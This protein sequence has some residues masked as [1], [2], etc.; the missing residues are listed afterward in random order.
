MGIFRLGPPRQSA[1]ACV[2]AASTSGHE[3]EEF[4]RYGALPACRA[5]EQD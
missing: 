3:L 1:A 5:F 2:Y 4:A